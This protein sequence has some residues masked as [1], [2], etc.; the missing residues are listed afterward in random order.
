MKQ[1]TKEFEEKFIE[2][3]DTDLAIEVVE[4]HDIDPE[5]LTFD[6]FYKRYQ[7]LHAEKYGKE[8]TI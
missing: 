1:G 8:L 7:E 3:T 2:K 5:S 4:C 6:I